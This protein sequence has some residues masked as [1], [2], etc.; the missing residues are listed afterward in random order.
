M[1]EMAV[2][3]KERFPVASRFPTASKTT[4]STSSSVAAIRTMHS[5][6]CACEYVNCIHYVSASCIKFYKREPRGL[7]GE[8]RA[9]AKSSVPHGQPLR[10]GGGETCLPK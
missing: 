8:V 10:F 3:L 6:R 1:R 4:S 7:H 5:G 9:C 2:L